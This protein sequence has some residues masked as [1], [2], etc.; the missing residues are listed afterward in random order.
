LGPVILRDN[1]L[2]IALVFRPVRCELTRSLSSCGMMVVFWSETDARFEQGRDM[3]AKV[4][5][6]MVSS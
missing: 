2:C 3:V 1:E 6:F 4:A 5:I